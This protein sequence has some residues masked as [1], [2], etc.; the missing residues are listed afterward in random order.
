L[1]SL[2]GRVAD[3]FLAQL[4]RGELPDPEEYAARFPQAAGHIRGALAALRVAGESLG[5]APP[6]S[7]AAPGT[8]GDFQIV[9]E[10]GRGGMG[11]VYEA[12]Q[13]TLRRRVALKVLPFAAVMDPRHLQRFQSEALAAA[14][15]DHPHLVK[16]YGVG[17]DRGVHYIAMQF[18]D[19][20]PLSDL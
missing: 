19:G 2:V 20:R 3:E 12:E 14:G 9:R 1:E 7:P 8:L 11:V 5:L 15:L 17:Q 6:P 18:V 10:V 4:E 16:V 13:L